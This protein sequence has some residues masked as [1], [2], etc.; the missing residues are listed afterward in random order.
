MPPRPPQ[1]TSQRR[2]RLFELNMPVQGAEM[3]QIGGFVME[4]CP[5]EPRKGCQRRERQR[6]GCQRRG[7][8]GGTSQGWIRRTEFI[9]LFAAHPIC[10]FRPEMANWVL[11]VC[12]VARTGASF[13]KRFLNVQDSGQIKTRN[14]QESF[15]YVQDR[16]V[17]LLRTR[18]L[19]NVAA[20]RNMRDSGMRAGNESGVARGGIARSGNADTR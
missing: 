13:S 11:L 6:R 7:A 19:Q 18:L 16:R 8:N 17:M 4:G 5:G 2:N 10:F 12:K 3:V 9:P 1:S 14:V 15:G 20:A